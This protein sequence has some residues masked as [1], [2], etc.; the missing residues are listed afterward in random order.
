MGN[1]SFMIDE[2]DATPAE[3]PRLPRWPWVAGA[4]ALVLTVA[5]TWFAVAVLH[6]GRDAAAAGT[7]YRSNFAQNYAV[8]A[9]VTVPGSTLTIQLTKP[10]SRLP[11]DVARY[12]AGG[13]QLPPVDGSWVGVKWRTSYSATT[14]QLSGLLGPLRHRPTLA[15]RAD[16]H[17]YP[18]TTPQQDAV[19]CS[20]LCALDDTV[21][22]ALAGRG[23]GLAVLVTFD[24]VTQT[25]DGRTGAIDK[26]RA[27]PLYT[28]TA[29][30]ARDCAPPALPGGY[31][32]VYAFGCSTA[33]VHTPWAPSLGWAPTGQSWVIAVVTVPGRIAV[34]NSGTRFTSAYQVAT[35]HYDAPG[36]QPVRTVTTVPG[37][38]VPDANIRSVTLVYRAAA[39][40]AGRMTIA[41][42]YPLT[43]DGSQP[44]TART[45][46]VTAT[47]T[48]TL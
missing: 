16:G 33:S 13:P 31:T 34:R 12:D 48:V 36:L 15:L 6:A 1:V 32:L 41:A 8:D 29:T 5:G 10:L 20:S 35:V 4:I 27:A 19:Y 47:W 24:G 45:A 17:T 21:W 7:T 43:P 38:L 25:V 40:A 30:A 2:D 11:Q 44:L 42:R 14:G 23:K 39:G 3:P 9:A 26:G 28:A 46:A 22:V 18:L 37:D